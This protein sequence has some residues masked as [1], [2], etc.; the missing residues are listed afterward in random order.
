[1]IFLCV[2]SGLDLAEQKKNF[3]NVDLIEDKLK[4]IT[5]VEI[6]KSIFKT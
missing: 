5:S 6:D 3:S 1:M 4:L 2:T